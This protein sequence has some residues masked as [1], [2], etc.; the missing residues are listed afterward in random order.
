MVLR[1]P[2]L[3]FLGDVSDPLT[4]KTAFGLRDWIPG[5]VV[6][7]WRLTKTTLDLGLTDLDPEA[8][9]T[10]GA[11]SIVIGAAPSGGAIPSGWARA[12]LR[13]VQAGLD[14]VSGL[15]A[16]LDSVPG[17]A[18]AA[19]R[20]G[21]RLH[22]V[23]KAPPGLPVGT[24]ARRPGRRLLT[25]GTDCAIGKKYTALALARAMQAAGVDAEFR[26]TGQTGILIA[27]TGI[28]L[29]TV[30]A[31]FMAG[32]AEAV[33]PAAH[34]EHWDVIEG[35]GSLFHPSYAG[36]SLALLH[37]SQPDA[38][39]LCTDATRVE[40][41]GCPGYPLPSLAEAMRRNLEA[42]RLTNAAARFVGIAI[43]TLPL[44]GEAAATLMR[45]LADEHGIPCVDPLRSDVQPIVDALEC[46]PSNSR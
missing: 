15:H 2:Y 12:L 23:R 24:G 43:N 36:I 7:Q 46:R 1:K 18:A 20:S 3:L 39:V 10:A 16:S 22:D 19:D 21:V 25:V 11:G 45:R 40:I 44:P 28:A 30:V 27:G 37:G 32:A 42:A 8:A 26:A 9:I 33:S 13:A 5:D 41:D 14:V 4:L 17:L 31:D 35:Q 6:G 34:P 38:L 29:D